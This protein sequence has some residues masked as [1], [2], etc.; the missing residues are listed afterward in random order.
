MIGNF[1]K[2]IKNIDTNVSKLMIKGINFSGSICL[3]ALIIL[4]SYITYPTTFTVLYFS[5][6]LFN[7]GLTFA[8]GFFICGFVT[9]KL[10]KMTT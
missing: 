8:I 1:I 3:L 10:K 7:L 6:A 5:L 9:D 2:D 4:I